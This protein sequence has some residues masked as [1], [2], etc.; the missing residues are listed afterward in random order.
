[1]LGRQ[2]LSPVKVV[3]RHDPAIDHGAC[4]Y[5]A[6]VRDHYAFDKLAFRPDAKPTVF[7]VKPLTRR[8][9]ALVD[10]FSGRRADEVRVQ[11][12]LQHVEGYVLVGPDGVEEILESP[13]RVTELSMCADEWMDRA[14]FHEDDVAALSQVI[15]EI[16][17]VRPLSCK[18]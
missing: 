4:S 16:T 5:D 12:A 7:V 11:C 9:R 17:D 13:P 14:S 10:G 2:I 6:Y 3:L 1:M 18:R 15:A 8:Q